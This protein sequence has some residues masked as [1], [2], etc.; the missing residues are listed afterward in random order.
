MIAIDILSIIAIAVPMIFGVHA[1]TRPDKLLNFLGVYIN[2]EAALEAIN[3]RF[4][5]EKAELSDLFLC[6]LEICQSDKERNEL[7]LQYK[8]AIE[9]LEFQNSELFGLKAVIQRKQKRLSWR[10][11]KH[12]APM[13]T[14]CLTCMSSFWGST[15]VLLYFSNIY[16]HFAGH[17]IH[18][19]VCLVPIMIA[20]VIEIICTIPK[21]LRNLTETVG[22]SL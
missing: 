21:S 16:F 1:V 8:K 10:I 9:E 13:L 14:E 7:V 5:E 20:G 4:N 17:D 22:D 6:D 2:E 12:F 3:S 18:V 19:L 15:I 11:I